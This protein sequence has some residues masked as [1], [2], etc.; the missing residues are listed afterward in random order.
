MFFVK[1]KLTPIRQKN[2]IINQFKMP[3][4][5]SFQELQPSTIFHFV[6]SDWTFGCWVIYDSQIGH[7]Y[8]IKLKILVYSFCTLVT[9]PFRNKT[10][11]WLF[12]TFANKLT[13]CDRC[14]HCVHVSSTILSPVKFRL[15]QYNLS[16][17]H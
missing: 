17:S 7:K 4:S 12:W 14:F 6:R 11:C 8:F 2:E 5:Q 13:K 1:K 16:Y 15:L 10:Y 3:M 9:V